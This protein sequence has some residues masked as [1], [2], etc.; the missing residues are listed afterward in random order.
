MQQ[1][2]GLGT[3]FTPQVCKA[4]QYTDPDN[5]C[6]L[7]C[8]VFIDGAYYPKGRGGIPAKNS[9]RCDTVIAVPGYSNKGHQAHWEFVVTKETSVVPILKV[10]LSAARIPQEPVAAEMC[11]VQ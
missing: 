1:L 5:A 10:N 4:L 6:L 3:Y 7:L 8:A 11:F 9:E 2:Y